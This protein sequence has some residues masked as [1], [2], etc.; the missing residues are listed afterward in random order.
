MKQI[1]YTLLLLT[2]IGL[3]SCKK[4]QYQPTI[5]QY[6][7]AQIQA[8]ISKNGITG[9]IKDTSGMYYKIISPGT[10]AP[11]QYTDS[12]GFVYTAQTP[13][14]A[15]VSTD[16][17]ANHYEGYMGEIQAFGGHPLGLQEAIH[18]ILN[19]RGASMR[20]IV[21]SHLAF[22]V[23]GRST[24]SSTV[25]GNRINGNQC[26]DYYVNI[27]NDQNAYDQMVIKNYIAANGLSNSM[28][29]DPA[30]YW[31]SISAPGIGTSPITNNTT[32][33]A[34]YTLRELNNV[35]ITDFNQPTG[36]TINIPDLI[37][38][39][40]LGLEKYA[41]T[42]SLMMFL[43]PSSLGT[44]K[45]ADGLAPPNSCLRYEIQILDVSP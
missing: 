16:T 26:L 3:V 31:Y 13:D 43:L 40:Q 39:M 20:L 23:A 9:M 22:G 33:T 37:P 41:S 2:V 24:G 11:L 32:I 14:G 34:T 18:N 38:G 15:Y 25:A 17:I 4:N 42:G 36:T 35:K 1:I 27:M 30:G 8:Y 5:D 21:P 6:D 44:G 29:Y 12:I 19:H 10:G 28:K 7:D 45:Q